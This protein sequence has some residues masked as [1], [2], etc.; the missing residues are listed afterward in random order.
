MHEVELPLIRSGNDH[1]SVPG[2]ALRC[3][4]PAASKA[5]LD[6]LLIFS[7]IG[8]ARIMEFDWGE[9]KNAS[10][11][12]KHRLSFEDATAVFDDPQSV[13]WIC[14]DPADDEERYM[15]VGRL[16]WNIV[17]VVYTERGNKLRLISA[18]EANRDERREYHRGKTYS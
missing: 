15:I 10:N 1:C 17:S 4:G 3:V 12:R 14:S 13:E 7:S 16:G 18:R 5:R 9:N 2:I 8:E 11:F 6:V